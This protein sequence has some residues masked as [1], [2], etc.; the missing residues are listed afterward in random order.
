MFKKILVIVM[1]NTF[2]FGC[3][4]GKSRTKSEWVVLDQAKSLACSVW[5]K[6][7]KD[8]NISEITFQPSTE[9]FLVKGTNRNTS[10]FSYD[11]KF[12]DDEDVAAIGQ[13]NFEIGRNAQVAGLVK[14]GTKNQFIV[15]EDRQEKTHIEFRDRAK[16]VVEFSFP[17]SERLLSPMG[18]YASNFG[19]WISY[20]NAEHMVRFIFIDHRMGRNAKPMIAAAS[21]SELPRV[22]MSENDGSIILTTISDHNKTKLEVLVL[23][24]TGKTAGVLPVATKVR[25]QIESYSTYFRDGNLFISFVDGDS[26]VGESSLKI[27]K[28]QLLEGTLSMLWERETS[29]R[30]VHVNEPVFVYSKKGLE[31]LVLKWVD[32]E[33]TIARYMVTVDGVSRP[34]YSGV[35]KRGSRIMEAFSSGTGRAFATTRSK[36]SEDWEFLVCRL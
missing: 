21:F 7:E 5:P 26:L 19:V 30:N 33:S 34:K 36:G 17:M 13:E 2:L 6:R 24:V 22:N 29:L 10:R 9:S 20:K 1:V 12:D 8:L 32:E 16:N 25:H 11:V 28:T 18:V 23:D 27:I 31:L 15:F 14:L 4:F 3:T 35:F